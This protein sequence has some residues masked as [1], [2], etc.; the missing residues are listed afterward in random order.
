M[1]AEGFEDSLVI[2][3]VKDTIKNIDGIQ[4]VNQIQ[5]DQ[6]KSRDNLIF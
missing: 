4:L 3:E 5:I 2:Q 1:L 6:L